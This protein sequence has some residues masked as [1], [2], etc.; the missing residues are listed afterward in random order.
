[1]RLLSLRRV[2]ASTTCLSLLILAGCTGTFP[3]SLPFPTQKSE[4]ASTP[5]PAPASSPS[6]AWRS[7]LYPTAASARSPSSFSFESDRFLQDFSYAGYAAGEKP[8]PEVKAPVYT[9]TDAAFG[10]DPS[11]K[12]DST[13]AIQTALDRAGQGGGVVLLPAGTYRL[14]VPEG[15]KEA[16]LLSKPNVVLRGA[17]I[18]RTFLVNTTTVMRGSA[19]VRVAPPS[20]GGAFF[21]QTKTHAPLRTD[22]LKPTTR[23]PVTDA[24][25]FAVGDFV[26]LRHDTTD[27]WV[28]EQ[29]EP[30][31]LGAGEKLR[32]PSYF[33]QVM[34]VDAAKN[35]LMIDVPIRHYLKVRDQ[36][37]VHRVATPP[38]REVGIEHFSIGNREHTGKTW[39]QEDY[40]VPGTAA[41]DVSG[42]YLISFERV[43][44]CWARHVAS[45]RPDG[46]TGAS[47]LSNG[48]QLNQASRVTVAD[49]SFSHPQY[50]G[51]GG[52]GY[53]F[54]LQDAN[55]CL[56]IRCSADFARHGFL[57]SHAGTN[58]TVLHA[59]RDSRTG[60]SVTGRTSGSGSDHHMHFSHANLID[61]CTANDSWW[62]ARYRPYGSEPIHGITSAHSVF[63][64][65]EGLGRIDRALVVSEQGRYGYVIGTRG[66]RSKVERPSAAPGGGTGP[67]DHV[68]G[69][70]RGA[71]LQPASLYVDQVQRRT[72]RPP[73]Q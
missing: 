45:Y 1:M 12:R 43:R 14:S 3:S 17:G 24:S 50:G 53:M 64:N 21:A 25:A 65:T 22:L 57:I 42:S 63:W 71:S 4:P 72:G 60:N 46:N 54:R 47:F 30:R 52:N 44:D 33:R 41:H 32:S 5:K 51:G 11:G 2:F 39:G 18:D 73:Q 15:R 19:V 66:T 68:E 67:V 13:R 69:V 36:A 34:S 10:A 56:V 26:V 6:G 62:E 40:S 70:G 28:K 37:R 8:L 61:N 59:C 38:L 49:C 20:G 31:W 58:G 48:I 9:V 7:E 35:V 55:D 16:L 23:I 29:G 27:A